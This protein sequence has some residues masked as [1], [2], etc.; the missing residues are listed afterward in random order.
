MTPGAG[1][2]REPVPLGSNMV[3]K[4]IHI[5]NKIFPGFMNLEAGNLGIR[6][7]FEN[8]KG[9]LKY[10]SMLLRKEEGAGRR[11]GKGVAWNV[12]FHL[13]L[14][15]LALGS[16]VP[17]SFFSFPSW[18]LRLSCTPPLAGRTVASLSGWHTGKRGPSQ[19]KDK[20]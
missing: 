19:G 2:Y 1:M 12:Y 20:Q 8:I 13:A 11:K 5:L 9:I 6:Q 10:N 7:V 16:G 17:Y 14:L 18:E 3:S 15:S 4:E